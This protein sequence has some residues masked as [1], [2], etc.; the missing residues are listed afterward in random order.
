MDESIF[1]NNYHA[2]CQIKSVW[3]QAWMLGDQTF[4]L[5]G[6]FGTEQRL[7]VDDMAKAEWQAVCIQ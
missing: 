1:N 4:D 3:S 6:A 7:K 5:I 2:N